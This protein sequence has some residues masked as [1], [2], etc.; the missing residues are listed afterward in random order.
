MDNKLPE[1]TYLGVKIM[2]SKR[3]KGKTWSRGTN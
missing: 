1:T 3:Q 2:N